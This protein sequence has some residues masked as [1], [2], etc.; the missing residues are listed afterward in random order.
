MTL[1][2]VI[3]GAKLIRMN[4]TEEQK[5]TAIVSG[6]RRKTKAWGKNT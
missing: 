1:R 6:M 2:R 4:I 5:H 3:N